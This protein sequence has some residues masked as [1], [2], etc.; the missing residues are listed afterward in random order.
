MSSRI[1]VVILIA[2]SLGACNRNNQQQSEEAAVTTET[3][4]DSL[5]IEMFDDAGNPYLQKVPCG[6]TGIKK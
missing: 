1:F 3:P 5:E 2:I 4:C 6:D